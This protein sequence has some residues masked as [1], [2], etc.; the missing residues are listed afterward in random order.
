MTCQN[1]LQKTQ[2]QITNELPG[3][4]DNLLTA[5]KGKLTPDIGR[6]YY[7]AYAQFFNQDNPQCDS[8]Y[9]SFWP[10]AP[11]TYQQPL[12]PARRKALNF[13]VNATNTAIQ[14]AVTRAGVQVVFVDYDPSSVGMAGIA[15]LAL[16]T[17]P[18]TKISFSFSSV[19]LQTSPITGKLRETASALPQILAISS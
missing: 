3:A 16:R 4:L 11:L 10:L 12:D 9:W 6:I 14:Q 5:A 18:P 13:L 2:D 1:T 8:I 7:T 17:I 19:A 15:R